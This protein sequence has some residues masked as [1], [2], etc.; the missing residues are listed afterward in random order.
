[1]RFTIGILI[2]VLLNRNINPIPYLKDGDYILKI[3][4]IEAKIKLCNCSDK[5]MESFKIQGKEIL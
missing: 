5:A 4:G 2:S 1:M 3:A